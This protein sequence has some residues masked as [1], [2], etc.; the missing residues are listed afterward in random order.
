MTEKVE[1]GWSFPLNKLAV[2]CQ[3]DL[4]GFAVILS[5]SCHHGDGGGRRWWSVLQRSARQGRSDD[6]FYRSA[7]SVTFRRH[8]AVPSSTLMAEWRLLR[9]L[10]YMAALQEFRRC[11]LIPNLSASVPNRRPYC[12][13]DATLFGYFAPS[14]LSPAAEVLA[15]P[16]SEDTS[17]VVEDW[18]AFPIL[19][20]R[21]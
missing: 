11:H 17:M 15:V 1:S 13:S 2:W 21:S 9:A 3:P 12:S 14:V 19:A 18:I 7:S 10:T 8:Q 4:G 5:L 6:A 20:L 16:G